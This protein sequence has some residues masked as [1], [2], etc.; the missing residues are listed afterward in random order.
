M[1]QLLVIVT[2]VACSGPEVAFEP[3]TVASIDLFEAEVQPHIEERCGSGGCHGRAERPLS[4]FARGAYRRDATRTY[5][6]EPLTRAELEENARRLSSFAFGTNAAGSLAIR[7]PLAVHAGGLWHGG[8]DTFYDPLDPAC[9][10][11]SEWL[12]MREPPA[13]GGTP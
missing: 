1:R 7:K 3:I 5:L 13:D 8:G 12:D 6:D 11:I 2:L 9:V 4:V 10:A